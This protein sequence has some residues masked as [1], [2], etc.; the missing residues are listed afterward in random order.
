[1]KDNIIQFPK[2]KEEELLKKVFNDHKFKAVPKVQ[3]KDLDILFLTLVELN[4]VFQQLTALKAYQ[5]R[6]K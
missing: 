2:R 3:Q 5:E 4:A 6:N 1:M